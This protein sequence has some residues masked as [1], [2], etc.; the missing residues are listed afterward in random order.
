MPPSSCPFILENSFAGTSY[1]AGVELCAWAGYG[2]AASCNG[3]SGPQARTRA[4][5][6][7]EE[8]KVTEVTAGVW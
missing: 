5:A 6:Y 2:P 8:A 1:R 4:R 3:P 7:C